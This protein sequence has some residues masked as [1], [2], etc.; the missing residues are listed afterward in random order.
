MLLPFLEQP[1]ALAELRDEARDRNRERLDLFDVPV[2]LVRGLLGTG[3]LLSLPPLRAGF[4]LR[5]RGDRPLGGQRR[6]RAVPSGDGNGV[7]GTG[8]RAPDDA[9]Q[10]EFPLLHSEHIPVGFGTRR[11]IYI[12]GAGAELLLVRRYSTPRETDK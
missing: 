6:E 1:S 9:R 4:G 7:P 10:G 12:I 5:P 8:E 2:S 3:L 11:S